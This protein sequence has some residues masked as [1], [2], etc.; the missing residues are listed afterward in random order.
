MKSGTRS[1]LQ[2]PVQYLAGVGPRR[3]ERF[4]RLGIL[5]A[6]DLLYHIPH[7]YEDAT[8]V[9]EIGTLAIGDEATIIGRVVSKGVLPTRRGLRIFRAVLRDSSGLIECA[10]PGQPWLDRSISRGDAMLVSGSVHFYHGRQFRPREYTVLARE[11]EQFETEGRVF[12]VY[13]ATEGLSHRQIRT[14]LEDNLE[15]LLEEVGDRELLPDEWR[16][17]FDLPTLQEALRDLH[18]PESL[19]RV[20]RSRRR[21]AFEELF[22]IQLLHARVGRG[23]R[24]DRA[25]TAYVGPP[26]LTE[27][28][29]ANLSFELTP[30][31]E[32]VW[33]E[34]RR[35]MESARRM[36]RLLQGDVGSGKTVVAILAMLKAAENGAQAALM[37]PTELLA[38]QHLRTVRSL[39]GDEG[40]AI[41][42]LT[43]SVTGEE[44]RSVLAGLAS[45][46]LL[47]VVG[48]HA[49]LQPTVVFDRL[50]CVVIDE[51]HRFGVEQRR[52]LRD[53]GSG[54][55]TLVMS[56]TPIPR[57]LA[58][59]L[60][61]DL[62]QS[63]IDQMPPGRKKIVT[64]VRGPGARE[65]AFDFLREQLDE[66]C[67]GYVV[68][69]LVEDSA[70]ID[71][72]SATEMA[73][74]LAERLAPH[75]V[76][77]LHGRMSG[78]EK[79]AV[80]RSFLA[81]EVQVLVATTVIEVGIDVPN[82][83]VMLIENA[84]RFGLAQL[85]QL[86][87][88]VG[89]GSAQSYCVALH[90]SA[91]IPDRLAAFQRSQDGFEL[92]REDLRL[93]GEGNLFGAEQHG[94]ARLRFAD[95]ERDVDL[96]MRARER[97]RALVAADPDLTSV[98]NRGFARELAEHY[99]D[100]E[101][102]FSVG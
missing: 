44:R 96:L 89:R 70:A 80:M 102:L 72:R 77:L 86:R 69:P 91:Q 32:R 98:P 12:P 47:L 71:A 41:S 50:G 22:F 36:Y 30:A 10:W 92:A 3:A 57:S 64:G 78:S 49:L 24:A 15:P 33:D 84:E 76:A 25:G 34:I 28:F 39:L 82:A 48:T 6:R 1:L 51:Q 11:S 54:S 88:R 94:I 9:R 74:T 7:R 85:H 21:L 53:A 17:E 31:Q 20:E 66:G 60:Y 18:N 99:P 55:D 52:E 40:P 87:G 26:D 100:Q 46:S 75:S 5:T 83:S 45:G 2:K 63:I 101:A 93:R 59:T 95:L 90:S 27:P 97:A 67:Q 65:K 13:P 58:L 81:G 19:A 61:G 79:E 16:T 43:S 42:L 8:T 62:D 4:A 38:E 68:Y 37:A 29:R 73:G 14:I 56:A 35:D 23:R